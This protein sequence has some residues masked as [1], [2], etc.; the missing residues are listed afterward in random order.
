MKDVLTVSAPKRFFLAFIL[1]VQWPKIIITQAEVVDSEN[2][3]QESGKNSTNEEEFYEQFYEWSVWSPCSRTCGIGIKFKG[4]LCLRENKALCEKTSRIY[5]TCNTQ[6]CPQGSANFRDVQCGQYNGRDIFI[7]GGRAKWMSYVRGEN[8]CLLFCYPYGEDLFYYFGRAKDGTQCS[9]EPYG[10]C[11][12]GRCKPVGCDN[13]LESGIS[14]DKCRVCG[15]NSTTC[16]PIR[17]RVE[18]LPTQFERLTGYAK[19]MVI[20]KGSTSVFLTDTTWNYLALRRQNGEYVVNGNRIVNWSGM[21][22]V[23][24]MEVQYKR[25]S[26]NIKETIQIFGPT[27]EDLFV[28]S[29]LITGELN[30]TFE[31][32]KPAGVEKVAGDTP[33]DILSPLQMGWGSW[34]ACSA[35]CGGG[36]KVR[37]RYRDVTSFSSFRGK[38]SEVKKCNIKPCNKMEAAWSEWGPWGECSVTCGGGA[39]IRFRYCKKPSSSVRSGC[40]GKRYAVEQCNIEKCPEEE[41][42]PTTSEIEGVTTTALSQAFRT[43]EFV[44]RN[45]SILVTAMTSESETSSESI[46]LS[47]TVSTHSKSP[48]IP[49]SF[50]LHS[51]QYPNTAT[52]ISLQGLKQKTLSRVEEEGY[53]LSS[54]L[55]VSRFSKL[56][57]LESSTMQ[58]TTTYRSDISK[59][60]HKVGI[61]VTEASHH[62]QKLSESSV[63]ENVNLLASH[64]EQSTVSPVRVSSIS[65]ELPR[66]AHSTYNYVTQTI[67]TNVRPSPVAMESFAT[68]RQFKSPTNSIPSATVFETSVKIRFDVV[69]VETVFGYESERGSTVRDSK[70][71]VVLFSKGAAFVSSSLAP[72]NIT[73]QKR[74]QV[75]GSS[76]VSPFEGQISAEYTVPPTN[77]K[78]SGV[79][80]VS[81][82][83]VTATPSLTGDLIRHKTLVAPSTSQDRTLRGTKTEETRTLSRHETSRPSIESGTA[84][85]T[86]R[87]EMLIEKSVEGIP[88][89]IYK[90]SAWIEPDS[91]ML[92]R[93]TPTFLP[94]NQTTVKSLGPPLFES[95]ASSEL[96]V[97]ELGSSIFENTTESSKVSPSITSVN[98]YIKTTDVLS[99]TTSKTTGLING[100]DEL[101][102]SVS[103]KRDEVAFTSLKS[104]KHIHLTR[105]KPAQMFSEVESNGTRNES[106]KTTT[107]TTEV[108]HRG[109][110]FFRHC[111]H[112]IRQNRQ[113]RPILVAQINASL[114]SSSIIKFS[115]VTERGYLYLTTSPSQVLSSELKGETVTKHV[116][117]SM[118]LSSTLHVQSS[119]STLKTSKLLSAPLSTK[120]KSSLPVS[121]IVKAPFVTEEGYVYLTTSSH[122]QLSSPLKRKAMTQSPSKQ[123]KHSMSLTAETSKLSKIP[124]AS[125]IMKSS[126]AT[127]G[128]R[129][130]LPTETSLSIRSILKEEAI[131]TDMH[132]LTIL[133]PRPSML[134][135]KS[136]LRTSKLQLTPIVFERYSSLSV[137]STL[138]SSFPQSSP[139][140]EAMTNHIY[141]LTALSSRK[142]M[143]LSMSTFEASKR[144]K[145]HF[146]VEM[147]SSLPL[148]SIFR[149][150]S[151]PSLAYNVTTSSI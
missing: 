31:Y 33:K 74:P 95:Q 7:N 39:R 148:S 27:K 37:S 42:R 29:L 145:T 97:A 58:A 91:T 98:E 9:K 50:K 94:W 115:T 84:K 120:I 16:Q 25:L 35:S 89:S 62:Q 119:L 117:Y 21:F 83:K 140:G 77:G 41:T 22:K 71:A 30:T 66:I 112:C 149:S 132:S 60:T 6:P 102:T 51:I 19:L 134:S 85:V 118:N 28:T 86:L 128:G 48:E 99:T 124:S 17:G 125:S 26:N 40:P 34:T 138:T 82:N 75:A 111:Q 10:V 76:T 96:I 67:T 78:D 52:E 123:R 122:P 146:Y 137:P 108:R 113:Q 61:D 5:E 141:S 46:K 12:F 65:S 79:Q 70:P 63:R 139:S 14:M 73:T 1:L 81:T 4:Q 133:S 53:S 87:I 103:N 147:Y 56:S 126:I 105:I 23:G 54:T 2:G 104:T 107:A 68:A 38:E 131:T 93:K 72:E 18:R 11:V 36:I 90:S 44:T 151:V 130:S 110:V 69:S 150:S 121:S 32:W 136:T 15:G 47:Q 129:H 100:T 59:T 142:R 45:S 88:T 109:E 80:H 116:K 3:R 135:T 13:K 144:P 64:V 143:L 49:S 8:Q 92:V 114:L 101:I 20:P 127:Q 55:S 106:F 57:L 24:D 43:Q